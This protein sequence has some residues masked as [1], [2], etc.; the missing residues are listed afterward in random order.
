VAELSFWSHL[1][2]TCRAEQ[3]DSW[4]VGTYSRLLA[5]P[6]EGLGLILSLLLMGAR[7][8]GWHRDL[9]LCP[10]PSGPIWLWS[11]PD[12]ACRVPSTYKMLLAKT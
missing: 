11:Q 6:V 2:N 3:V 1:W 10:T 12:I 9:P 7:F 8:L 4:E 5:H